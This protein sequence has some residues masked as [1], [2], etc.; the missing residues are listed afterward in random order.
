MASS[1]LGGV[2]QTLRRATLQHDETGLTDGELLECYVRSREEAAFAA[3]VQRHGPMVWGVCRRILASHHDAEDAFQ[4]TFLVLVRK[5]ASVVP[6]AMLANWLYGVAH[7]TALKA[8]STAARRRTREKQVTAMPEPAPQQQK[9]CDDLQPLLDQELSRLPD[10]YR[11]VLVLCDLGGRTRK[12]AARHF[13]LPE[14][15][16]ATRL[17]TARAMLARRLARHG[18]TVSGAALAAVLS[19]TVASAHMPV[20][21]AASTIKAASSF[22]AG[23]AAAAGVVSVKAAALADGVLKTMLL[24]RLKITTVLLL[25]V[26][27]L[28]AGTVALAQRVLAQKPA[29]QAAAPRQES[30]TPPVAENMGGEKAATTVSGVVKAVDAAK[31][32]VTVAHREG[33]TTFSVAPDARVVVDGRPGDL[34]RLRNAARVNLGL[35]AGTT[36]AASLEAVGPEIH[37]NVIAVDAEKNSVTLLV[38]HGGGEQTFTLA[39]NAGITIDGKPG[40]LSG[41]PVGT[42]VTLSWFVDQRTARSMQAEGPAFQGVVVK[43][44]DADHN[45]ITFEDYGNDREGLVSGKTLAV[46]TD[47]SILID[48][49]PGK[50]AGIPKGAHVNVGLSVDRRTARNIAADGSQFQGVVVKAVDAANHT[51]TL[52]DARGPA[53]LAG[54][55]LSVAKNASIVIDGKPGKLAAVPPGAFLNLGLG[56][57]QKTVRNI[58]AEG[59]AFQSI[60]VKAVD[61]RKNTI[62]FEDDRAPIQLAGKT[63]AV[64]KDAFIE[65]DGK[66]GQLAGLPRGAFV[67]LGL[68]VDQTTARSIRAEGRMVDNAVVKA[69]DAP[70]YSI[71]IEDREGEKTFAV[72]RDAFVEIDGKPGRLAGVP[73]GAIV[74]LGLSVDGRT[75]RRLQAAGSLFFGVPVQA[76]DGE[77]NTI[78]FGE[79]REDKEGLVSGKTLAVATDASILIDGK[80][81]K[82][83]VVP[84][85]ALANWL[86]LSVDQKTVRGFQAQGPQVGGPGSAAAVVVAV[87]AGK[88]TI[89][90]DINGEGEKTFPVARD[91]TVLIDG[92]PGKL[93]TVPR[94]ATVTLTLRVDQKT[95]G[96]IETKGP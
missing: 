49:K 84:R 52:A 42:Q 31:N 96:G 61:A 4:A 28:G 14:G 1:R 83:A 92:K 62:T 90:I 15:T 53:E 24:T 94:D 80:P 18:L 87:D 47:S 39:R 19:Q 22:A 46:A 93:A 9:L 69:V 40:L 37:G 38:S 16:V 2:I 72:A 63:F 76:V 67:N 23:Q 77:R 17:A 75:V 5:A 71:D 44:V 7:Q 3:L 78:T 43:A 35:L 8:R 88:G 79:H 51:I 50:L 13:G 34:A 30:S 64:A 60:Q 73:K 86:T 85:G 70:R 59:P 57:D 20:G 54:R 55:T 26:A 12:E 58:A 81:A 74:A 68:S 45:T 21:V 95:V 66:P 36:T 56:V 27:V 41:V 91:A 6:R 65:I 32:T 10:K 89:T 25:A 33:Q 29:D 48:G 11:A 82:L